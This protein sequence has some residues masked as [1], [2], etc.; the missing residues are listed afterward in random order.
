MTMSTSNTSTASDP[1]H[2]IELA[3]DQRLDLM[4]LLSTAEA[5]K[6]TGQVAEAIALYRRWLQAAQSPHAHIA[7]FNLGVAL[8]SLNDHAGAEAVYRQAIAVKA[9][10][11]EAQI[12]LGTQIEAQGRP[13]E[14][15]ELW[16]SV[17]ERGYVDDVSKKPLRIHL[18]NNLGRSLETS[19]RLR[20]AEQMLEQSLRLDPNQPDVL[21]HW[22]HL[23]QK[24]CEWPVF[25][26]V[27][28]VDHASMVRA[29][30]PLAMLAAFD[31]PA[32]QMYRGGVFVSKKV[33]ADWASLAAPAPYGHARLRV[34]YLSSDFC[35]HA[36]S[37]LTVELFELHDRA[38]F[39]VYG[40]SWSKDDGSALR[41]RVVG[42][43]DHYV[44]IG[45]MTDEQA[46]QAIRDR[47]IDI[48][49]DLQGL[50]SGARPNILARR[51]ATVQITYLG[52]PGTSA[53]PFIDYVLADRFVLPQALTPCFIEKPLYLPH[54]FQASDR[55]RPLGPVP[56]R[57]DLGL[58]DDRFV[59]CSFN[60]NYK[61]N[62]RIFAAWMRILKRVPGSV[63]WLLADNEW[64]QANMLAAAGSHGIDAAR[65]IF[66]PRVAPENYLARYA[67]ADLFLDTVPFN[68][69]ATA[70]DALWMGLPLLTCPGSTFASRM[71]GSLLT[72]LGLP[73]LIARDLDEYESVAARIGNDGALAGSL[74]TKLQAAKLE[75]P[76]F[77]SD[78]FVRELE[79]AFERVARPAAA[80]GHT[81]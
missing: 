69:G 66:A 70:N 27:G 19:R 53:M 15:I 43:M 42:A 77:R 63:L 48:L 7:M 79:K 38:R 55:R 25:A 49:V 75:S 36:V 67:A 56:K 72:T 5:L 37:L 50:T 32:L 71:A 4:Q 39:E 20:E 60:N 74:K 14:A 9:D 73:E 3:R 76:L 41:Q 78:E 52:F 59:F 54:C 18:L 57:A 6:A 34:G 35:Q 31:D 61:I 58:P 2:A 47:E 13:L 80:P 21:Q 81:N 29:A 1:A 23:R 68:A 64:A 51:P 12:N 65:L 33:T 24:Q 8:G 30:S 45:G 46:A 26:P 22:V 17:L 28:Q 62:E 10:F 44:P 40:F 11:A 16:R